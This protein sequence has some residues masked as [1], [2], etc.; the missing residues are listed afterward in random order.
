MWGWVS[1]VSNENPNAPISK[2]HIELVV[3]N[4]LDD[5]HVQLEPQ[6]VETH[7]NEHVN[8]IPQDN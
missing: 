1:P 5:F 8:E 3:E 4:I 6:N 7:E 2:S